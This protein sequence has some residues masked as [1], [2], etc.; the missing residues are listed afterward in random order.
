M[1]YFLINLRRPIDIFEHGPFDEVV[2]CAIGDGIED[3]VE[4]FREG[5]MVGG[6]SC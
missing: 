3:A 4:K 5:M 2:S 1:R 6:L